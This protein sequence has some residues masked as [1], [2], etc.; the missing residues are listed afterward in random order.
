MLVLPVRFQLIADTI[1]LQLLTNPPL[2]IVSA[3]EKLLPSFIASRRYSAIKILLV[4]DQI[5][6]T[7]S[8]INMWPRSMWDYADNLFFNSSASDECWAVVAVSLG[9]G[10]PWVYMIFFWSNQRGSS[11]DGT[12]IDYPRRRRVVRQQLDEWERRQW[13]AAQ[14]R[15]YLRMAKQKWKK[16]QTVITNEK[17]FRFSW[18][19]NESQAASLC[20]GPFW[21]VEVDCRQ[22]GIWT[23]E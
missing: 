21:E 15:A 20:S 16:S 19:F 11:L 23:E 1:F 2:S 7:A 17:K 12:F 6:K 22:I 4:S 18:K 5:P 8:R 14:V 10:S 13:S 3:D 9:P